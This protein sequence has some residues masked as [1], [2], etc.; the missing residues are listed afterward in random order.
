MLQSI[1]AVWF[2]LAAAALACTP[3]Q[4]ESTSWFFLKDCNACEAGS[5]CPDGQTR[6]TCGAGTFSPPGASSCTSCS[7]GSFATASA[8]A[9]CAPCPAGSYSQLSGASRCRS[10][11]SGTY[12][13]QGSSSCVQCPSGSGS[14]PGSA[15]ASD[16]KADC[17][18]VKRQNGRIQI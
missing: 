16:C 17:K 18:S 12:S 9:S 4:Y 13:S 15:F 14:P 5:K 10:C 7:P 8:S 1:V 2:F 3:G 6:L 11:P